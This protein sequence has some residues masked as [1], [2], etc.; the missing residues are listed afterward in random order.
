MPTCPVESSFGG[1]TVTAIAV[2]QTVTANDVEPAKEPTL[3]HIN[4]ITTEQA[5]SSSALPALTQAAIVELIQGWV[6]GSYAPLPS[7]EEIM[8]FISKRA[9]ALISDWLMNKRLSVLEPISPNNTG[10]VVI[11]RD[12]V[13]HVHTSRTG[14]DSVSQAGV[15]ELLGH[16]FAHGNPKYA[17]NP[18]YTNQLLMFDANYKAKDPAAR[19]ESPVAALQF[20]GHPIAHLRLETAYWMK[21][22]KTSALEKIALKKK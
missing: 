5:A 10:C 22:A 4:S 21:P 16:L 9:S 12:R 15:V 19:G 7:T 11:S 14:K 18:N 6:D 20:C 2:T 1:S 17:P 3:I 8:W 13:E